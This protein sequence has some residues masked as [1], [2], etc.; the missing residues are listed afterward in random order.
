MWDKRFAG[1]DYFYGK[2]PAAFV[3]RNAGRI[4]PGGR[5]LSLA[6]GEGRN[7]VHLA[8]LGLEVHAL[9]RSPVARAK[10]RK[11]AQECGVTIALEDAD[12]TAHDW[13]EAAF[14]A[15]LG[16]FIQ[17]SAPDDGARILA[18]AGRAVRSGGLV[19]L[20]G[21][22]RRQVDYGTGGPPDV[23]KLWDLDLLRAAFPGWAVE[24]AEDYD[25]DLGEGRGH[26]GRAALIDFVARKP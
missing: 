20:H 17:F 7:A 11:L 3:A 14:D 24:V 13:P 22:A 1:E 6:E 26:D 23:A 10:A 19:L 5:V 9:E 16:I 25:A 2:A 15:V 18:G 4:A 12:L 21:F 8:G